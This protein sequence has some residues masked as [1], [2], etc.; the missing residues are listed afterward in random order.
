[1]NQQLVSSLRRTSPERTNRLQDL[2]ESIPPDPP[3][4]GHRFTNERAKISV[5]IDSE[6]LDELETT[7]R[8]LKISMSKMVE[9]CVWNY[10]D[11]PALSFQMEAKENGD[12]S[13]S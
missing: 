2:L 9:T 4:S 3:K 12:N 10:F 1:M 6:L 13:E 7:R 5:T 8:L 11:R